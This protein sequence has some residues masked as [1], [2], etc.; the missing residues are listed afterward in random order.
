MKTV[1]KMGR[2]LKGHVVREREVK[3]LAKKSKK[4]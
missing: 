4:K 3:N 2:K 1:E